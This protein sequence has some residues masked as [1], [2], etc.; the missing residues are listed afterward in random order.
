MDIIAFV[1]TFIT[2]ILRAEQDFIEEPGRF[3]KMEEAAGRLSSR[4]AADILGAALTEM[5]ELIAGS[6]MRTERFAAQRHE[7]RTLITTAGDVTFTHTMYKELKTGKYR[8]LLDELIH[9]PNHERFSAPAEAAVLSEAAKTSYQHAADS[10]GKGMQKVSKT[11]VMN[12]VHGIVEEIPEEEAVEKKQCRYLYIE[13]DE[14]HIHRQKCGKEINK[15]CMLGKL[16]YLFEGKKDVCKGKKRLV[17]PVFLGGLYAGTEGNATLWKRVQEHIAGHYD[18]KYLKT[19]YIS[20]DGAGWIRAGTDYVDRGVFVADRFHLMK[21]INGAANQML[22]DAA[23]VKGQIYKYI[24]KDKQGKIRK[25]LRKMQRCCP[26]TDRVD[27]LGK[28]LEGNWDAVQRAFHDRH[29]SG[30]SAEGHVS[31]LYSDRMSS[32]PMGWSETGADRMC[33]LRCYVKNNGSGKLI[34]LVRIRRERILQEEATGTDGKPV[35]ID[36][37]QSWKRLTSAQREY[38]PYVD[39]MQASIPSDTVR[40][41]LAIRYH[42]TEI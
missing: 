35:E 38:G 5:D 8:Y 39:R 23:A 12:K 41:E 32:R 10:M 40:K 2:G 14:D 30:C 22:D 26:N 31:H 21:Y 25:L 15:N 36:R 17:N 28:F 9:L 37:K 33:R 42:L 11:A 7:Q 29:V 1:N 13:A 34:D 24:Y 3:D 19:V 18:A 4:L 27:A 16:V 20:G 6:P